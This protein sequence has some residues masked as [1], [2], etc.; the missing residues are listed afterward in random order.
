MIIKNE[1]GK[2]VAFILIITFLSTVTSGLIPQN[3]FGKKADVNTFT[4]TVFAEFGTA[5]W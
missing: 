5:T 4:H 2:F 3:T 1:R